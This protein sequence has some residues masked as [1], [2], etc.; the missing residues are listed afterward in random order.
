MLIQ[1]RDPD[2]IRFRCHTG[3]AY[4]VLSLEAAQRSATDHPR[5]QLCCSPRPRCSSLANCSG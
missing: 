1:V 4:S 3:H 2:V 5:E